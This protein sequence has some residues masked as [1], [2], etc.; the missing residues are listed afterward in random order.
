MRTFRGAPPYGAR[1]ARPFAGLLAATGVVLLRVRA[2]VMSMCPW[3]GAGVMARSARP[4]RVPAVRRLRFSD[5]DERITP[6]RLAAPHGRG[7]VDAGGLL[8]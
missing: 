4:T 1:L 3:A 6:I 7:D 8:R 5:V 2:V